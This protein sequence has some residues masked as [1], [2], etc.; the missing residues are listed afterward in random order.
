MSTILILLSILNAVVLAV[1]S[2]LLYAKSKSF[3][4]LSRYRSNLSQAFKFQWDSS[5]AVSLLNFLSLHLLIPVTGLA[6]LLKT[7]LNFL[8][9]LAGILISMQIS[10]R[11]YPAGISDN[12]EDSLLS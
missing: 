2:Y 11:V 3:P 12:E 10:Q 8:A 1:T 5:S 6:F 4:T 9:V 7:D